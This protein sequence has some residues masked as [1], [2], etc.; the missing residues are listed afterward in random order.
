MQR[1]LERLGIQ[2]ES[3]DRGTLVDL[4]DMTVQEKMDFLRKNK[5]WK[6][7]VKW[8]LKDEHESTWKTNG[9]S[10]LRYSIVGKTDLHESKKATKVTADIKLNGAHWTNNKAGVD[11]LG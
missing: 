11:F 1:R 8:E 2:F 9:L 7:M 6:C 10:D 5:S 4:E 3:P